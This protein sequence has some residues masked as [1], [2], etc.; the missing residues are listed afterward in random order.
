MRHLLNICRWWNVIWV[1]VYLL[2]PLPRDGWAQSPISAFPPGTFSNKAALDAAPAATYQ[3]P[4]DIVASATAW[5]SCARAYNAAY[6][7]GTNSLCDLKDKTTGTVAI[8][9]LRIKTTGFVDLTGSYCTGSTTPTV[10]CAAAAG[11][12]CVVS[13]IYDQTGNGNDFVQATAADMPAI[14]F[15]D[16]NGLPSINCGTGATIFVP[17]TTTFT[18]NSFSHSVAYIRTTGTAAGGA[19][20]S[21]GNGWLG[22]GS[23]ANL[24]QINNASSATESATDNAWHGLQGVFGVSSN[25]TVSLNVDGNDFTGLSAGT[26]GMVSA[27]VRFCRC[28]GVQFANGKVVEAGFWNTVQF[29]ATQR[30]NLYQNMHGASGYNGAF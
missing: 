11:G 6:A 29:N 16:I 1:V 2:A 28:N 10:A 24:A 18:T 14:I 27:N 21:A 26:A 3:G 15:G 30:G 17:T 22:A 19:F 13:K 4:G 23:G 7:N 8:C 9:T 25:T 12:A 5:G 20:G